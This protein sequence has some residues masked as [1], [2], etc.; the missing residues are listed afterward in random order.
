MKKTLTGITFLAVMAMASCI[1]KG[2]YCRCRTRA[3]SGVEQDCGCSGE[4]FEI[5][6][7]GE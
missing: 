7:K 4:S 2:L 6:D 1:P 5:A 3:D